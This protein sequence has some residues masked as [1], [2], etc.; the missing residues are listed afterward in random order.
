MNTDRRKQIAAS[1][2]S[3]S[4]EGCGREKVRGQSFCSKCYYS[5]PMNN[6]KALYQRFGRGYEESYEKS[7][8]LIKSKQPVD[9]VHPDV[10]D[11]LKERDA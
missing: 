1:L 7:L 8:E 2:E 6:R 5:L 9:G 11:Y 10:A 3:K 4:C